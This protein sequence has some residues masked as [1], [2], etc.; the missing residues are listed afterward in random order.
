MR[1]LKTL[2]AAMGFSVAGV[3]SGASSSAP[4]QAVL[5]HFEYGHKDW[6]QFFAFEKTLEEAITS[7]GAGDY[8]GNELAVD[9]SDGDMYMYGPDADKL[10]AVV[11]PRLEAATFLKNVVVT[12]RYGSVDDSSAREVK[13]RMGS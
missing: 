11:K 4:D 12:L 1:L 7:S 10:Y 13:M 8:D 2:A 6:S 5:V 3:A 9:G